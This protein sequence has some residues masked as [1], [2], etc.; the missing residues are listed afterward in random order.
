M[1]T[2]FSIANQIFLGK[3]TL[4]EMYQ[5]YENEFRK[6][7]FVLD[8]QSEDVYKIFDKEIH[9]NEGDRVDLYGFRIVSWKC[10]DLDED[11]IIYSLDEE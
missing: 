7:G 5:D 11:M 6:Q 10:V 3:G 9:L 8:K 4:E 2:K 1:R